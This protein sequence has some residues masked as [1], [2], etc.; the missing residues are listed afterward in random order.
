MK[1][2]R[3]SSACK[4]RD[5][6]EQHPETVE[7]VLKALIEGLAFVLSPRNKPRVLNTLMKRLKISN[8]A[9]AEEGYQDILRDVDRRPHPSVE[10]VQNIQ[11]VMRMHNPR[12]GDIK[13]EDVIDNSF[14]R[15]LDETGFIDRLYSSY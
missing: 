2:P 3:R 5:R 1:M 9:F 15:R 10:A 14:V 12:V 6:F 8:P 7:N 11:R 13:V 4:S